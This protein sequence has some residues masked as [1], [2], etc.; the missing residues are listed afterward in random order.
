MLKNY[1]PNILHSISIYDLC[2]YVCCM[3]VSVTCNQ[4]GCC[5]LLLPHPLE[6]GPLP[7]NFLKL[8]VSDSVFDQ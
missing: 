2:M 4:A 8:P 3:H 7:N 1:I 5:L 6:W